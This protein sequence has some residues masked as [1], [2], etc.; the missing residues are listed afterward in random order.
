LLDEAWDPQELDRLRSIFVE[1]DVKHH[2]VKTRRA[3]NY[4]FIDFHIEMPPDV[5]LEQ[6]HDFCSLIE[7][8]IHQNFENA[9]ITIHAEPFEHRSE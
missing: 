3:G 2:D 7:S 6:V 1:M 4:R 8:E 5:P 9:Q